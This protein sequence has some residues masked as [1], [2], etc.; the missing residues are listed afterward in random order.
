[1]TEATPAPRNVFVRFRLG[2]VFGEPHAVAQQQAVLRSV[3]ESVEQIVAPGGVRELPYRW[4]RETYPPPVG[5]T[6]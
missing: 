6:G 2:Q 1:M 4:K 5:M 3:L